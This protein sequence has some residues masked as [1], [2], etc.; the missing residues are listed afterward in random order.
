[1][2]ALSL[3]CLT[4]AFAPLA[5]AELEYVEYDLGAKTAKSVTNPVVTDEAYHTGSKILFVRDTSL[6]DQTYYIGVFELTCAQARQLKLALSTTSGGWAYGEFTPSSSSTLPANLHFPTHAEWKAYTDDPATLSADARKSLNIYGGVGYSRVPLKDWYEQYL[7]ASPSK[8]SQNSHGVYDIYGNVA[9]Y[10]T[11]GKGTGPF[12]GGSAHASD[13]IE[14]LAEDSV[15]NLRNDGKLASRYSSTHQGVR[16]IYRAPAE[17]LYT[18]SVTLDGA[19]VTQNVVT[20]PVDTDLSALKVGTAITV[21]APE[22]EGQQRLSGREVKGLDSASLPDALDAQLTFDMPASDVTIAYTSE[23]YATLTVENGTATVTH[24]EETVTADERTQV[25]AGDV[26]TLTAREP[27][28]HERFTGWTV[29]VGA[30]E[31]QPLEPTQDETTGESVYRYEIPA[32]DGIA[33]FTFAAVFEP[34]PYATITVTNGTATVDGQPVT[35]V[36][37][38]DVVTLT[39]RALGAHERF[40]GWTVTVGAGEAQP[41]EPTQDETTGESVYRYEIPALDGIASFTFAADIR[42]YPRVLVFGGSVSGVSNGRDYRDG[43]YEPGSSLTLRADTLEGYVHTGWTDGTQS[44]TSSYAV[45]N[46]YDVP[47][48]YDV[49]I[50]L[51]AL[52]KTTAESVTPADIHL[53]ST[54]T[55]SGY[56]AHSLFGW[57]PGNAET[58]VTDETQNRYHAYPYLPAGLYAILNL[59]DGSLFYSDSLDGGAVT[60]GSSMPERPWP[61]QYEDFDAYL[62]A[63]EAWKKEWNAWDEGRGSGNFDATRLPLRRVIPTDGAAEFYLGVYETS[64][65][66]VANLQALCDGGDPVAVANAAAAYCGKN[67]RYV[68]EEWPSAFNQLRDDLNEVFFGGADRVRYPTP[69]DLL[70]VAQ[71]SITTKN[72][73]AGKGYQAKSDSDFT[74]TLDTNLTS[75]MVMGST[76]VSN[77]SLPV[78]AMTPC[79]GF[80]GLWGNGWE[81]NAD[82]NGFAGSAL[83]RLYQRDAFLTESVE[84][85]TND[86]LRPYATFR[87]VIDVEQ[88]VVIYVGQESAATAVQVAPGQRLFADDTKPTKAGHRFTGWTLGGDPIGTDHVVQA[89]DAGKVLTAVWEKTP[90]SVTMKCEH[91]LGPAVAYPGQTVTVH[92][93]AGR[94]FAAGSA[95]TIEPEAAATVGALNEDGTVTVTFASPLPSGGTVTLQGKLADPPA[96]PKPGYRFRLR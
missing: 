69:S 9:E 14:H 36:E 13:R 35:E 51:T 80:Y 53:G 21:T 38:G 73:N 5:P 41:L 84:L 43:Y 46:T 1:M 96:P 90:D 87:P 86:W 12:Y 77:A 64:M 19:D 33:S 75:A 91:C 48:T 57:T 39:A 81:L 54:K 34:I 95:L 26:V 50:T 78:N 92:P 60:G 23:P 49:T 88:T 74:S 25:V 17:Q 24:G 22:P 85:L 82:G 11:D 29:T 66:Q 16:L 68:C 2:K 59:K 20:N 37:A 72:P 44:V 45:P 56:Q 40:T 31:A 94:T 18:L 62:A 6:P 79:Y 30:G 10:A 67:D 58:T 93:P 52:Y 47:D 83:S 42:T 63:F 27:G 7:C 89:G 32:L 71:T 55:D 28:A 15:D 4:L 61:H 3:L 65:G 76:N 8:L 70:R